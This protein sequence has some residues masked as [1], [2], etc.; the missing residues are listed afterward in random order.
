MTFRSDRRW[1]AIALV[2]VLVASA[3]SSGSATDESESPPTSEPTDGPVSVADIEDGELSVRLRTGQP[4]DAAAQDPTPI[5]NGEPLDPTEVD[6]ILDRLGPWDVPTDDRQDFSRPAETLL[7][8]RTG[9]TV[10][11]PFPAG[12]EDPPPEP[13]AGPLEI[14]R[15]QP[16]GDV[17]IAPSISLTFNQPMVA[18]GTVDQTDAA[19]VPITISPEVAG[20]WQWIGTKT[21]RF[22]HDSD[23][24]DRLPMAT[25]YTVEVPAGTTSTTGGELAETVGF[26]FATPTVQLVSFGPEN[27]SLPLEPVFVATFDQHI[28]TEAV[29]ATITV[30]A[31]GEPVDVR[32]ASANEIEDDDTAAR[33]VDQAIDGRFVAFRADDPLPADAELTIRFGPDLPS[34]EGPRTNDQPESR[35]AR[36][37]A[38][39]QVTDHNCTSSRKCQPWDQLRVEFNNPL[40]E[41]AFDNS[42]VEIEPTVGDAVVYAVGTTINI[43]GTFEGDTTY[44]VTLDK[45]ITD[46]HGQQLADTQDIEFHIGAA[47]PSLDQFQNPLLTLDPFAPEPAVSVTTVNHDALR[48]RLFAVDPSEWSTFIAYGRSWFDD[49]NFGVGTPPWT[50]VTDTTIDVD[51][52]SNVRA[53]TLIDLS[54]AIDGEHGHVVVLV[55]PVGALAELSQQDDD[56]WSNR[57]TMVWAQRTDLGVDAFADNRDLV[58]WTTDLGTGKIRS[59]VEVELTVDNQ[60]ATSDQQGLARL[61]LPG[62]PNNAPLIAR[63]GDDSMLLQGGWQSWSQQNDRLWHVFDDRAMYRPGETAH[64]KGWV[65]KLTLATDTQLAPVDAGATVSYTVTDP[66][67]NEIAEGTMDVNALGGFDF[68]VDIP[69]GANLGHAN[70]EFALDGTGARRHYHSFQV[71]EFRRPEF[72]VR[73]RPESPAPYFVDQPATVAVDAT[74]FSGGPLPDADVE[75]VVTTDTA[76]YAPP[77]WPDFTF[78]TW[79]PCWDYGFESVGR[80]FAEVS[81]AIDGDY[82][83]GPQG[84][85]VAVE[86]FTAVT[87][88]DGSHYLEMGFTGDGDD[89]PTTVR[90]QAT[91]FDINR[92]AWSSTANL[93]VH[94]ADVYVGLR[95]SR[96]FVRQGEPL[97]IEAIVT[98]LDGEPVNGRPVELEAS[99]LEWR[100]QDG[101]WT[102]VAVDPETCQITST[103][104]AGECSFATDHGGTY[105]ISAAV[106]DEQGRQNRSEL[107]R[108]VSGGDSRPDRRVRQERVTL[109][110]GQEEYQPGDTAEILVQSP[111]GPAEGLVTVVRNGLVSTDTFTAADGS[112]VV[113]VPITDDLI[114]G[115]RVQVDLVGETPR[116]NVDGAPQTDLPPRPAFAT[117]SLDLSVPPTL[118]ALTVTAAPAEAE[119]EP[120]A[121]TSV[122]VEVTDAAGEPVSGAEVAVVVVDEAVLALTGYQLADPNDSFYGR[123]WGDD[124]DTRYGR[125]GIEL[126]ANDRFREVSALI[127]GDAGDA[128]TGDGGEALELSGSPATTTAGFNQGAEEDYAGRDPGD[129]AAPDTPIDV[130]D[131]FDALALFTPDETTGTDGTLSVDVDL[132]DSLTRYRVMAVAVAD[133]DSFGSGEANLTARLPIMVRPSAPRFLN[134][135]DTFEL[136][137]LVQNQ[138]DQDLDVE[139]AIETA[140]LALT[141]AA[142]QRVSVPANNRVEVRFAAEADDAGTARFRVAGVSGDHADAASGEL[143]VYTPTTSEAFATYGVVDD[144]T[145]SQP[146]L[147]PTDVVPQFGGLE[148]GTSS[149]ALQALTD[150]VLYL[151]D[152]RYESSDALA[153]RIMAVAALRDVLDAFSAE[154]LPSAAELDAAVDRDIADL[155]ALQNGDGGF[156]YWRRGDRSI[157]YNSIQSVHALVAAEQ[158]GYSLPSGAKTQGLDYLRSIEN[159][160]PPEYSQAIRNTL[161]A[162]ALNVRSLADDRDP[163]KAV[164]LY[165]RAGDSLKLDALAWLWPVLDDTV[166][167]AEIARTFENRATETAG[168]ATFATDYGDD[169]YVILHSSRRTDGIILRSLVSESPESDLIPKVVAGLLGNQTKGR[170]NNVQEN[171]FILLALNDYFDTF[172]S[173]TPDFV[174]RVWLGDLYA[175]EHTYQGRSTDRGETLVP[176]AELIESGDADI[177]VAKDGAGRLYYRLGLRYAPADLDL[178]PRDRGFVVQRSYEAVDDPDDVRRDDDGTWQVRAGAEVRV[179]LTMVA[180]SR[181]THVALTDPLPA[182]LEPLNPA[183]AVTP[184]V[185]APPDGDDDGFAPADIGFG[186]FP[187]YPWW[188]WYE[189]QNLRDDR[190]EAFTSLLSGGTYEYS[191]VARATTPG[192]FVVPPTKA[193]EIYAPE[194]FGRTAT[195]RLVVS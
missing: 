192:T 58:V 60:S 22:E 153:S 142:G 110:P 116:I 182:G 104:E 54:D 147:A 15:Y 26:Q 158:A 5:V 10:E 99:R 44:R 7:P 187:I 193:E 76:T 90:A 78:C 96:P 97:L 123:F 178:D 37:F 65:R 102:E 183:L 45:T 100:Y 55:E 18:L 143:P 8:P 126:T 169:A 195:D 134:F 23:L 31:N 138:T 135:G 79:V 94:P 2:F 52:E 92:Q 93:L 131:N 38:S 47:R 108:W 67:G 152:Y 49:E 145:I 157:P 63:S 171:V 34:A 81:V 154:G 75:W 59:G 113:E 136:P 144:G 35:T 98:D 86:T 114:P 33:L 82:Y 84:E 115:A 46:I 189:H 125:D 42:H 190:A 179:N 121:Q 41:A 106:T 180:D 61:A 3:C 87:G 57:P 32:L 122:A 73:A 185:P 163:A 83:P 95:S 71:Q 30:E 137:V 150:A 160:F 14:L 124:L 188:Q 19:D 159:H 20:R 64:F 119:V 117:G 155:V 175:G 161:S 69:E 40:D 141:E 80:G 16:E 53:E 167:R 140:N 168:A 48:V 72:E 89:Q 162:Y 36:T 13:P 166:A 101:E 27:D 156:P 107:T 28:D 111:F 120:G 118:R 164:S 128:A 149:T 174:A 50:A 139:V 148:V 91:V 1:F 186:F 105:E 11:Q 112:A 177:V 6:T 165:N 39:L 9:E 194:V 132:P 24:I 77:N 29:L 172:E 173:V 56:F 127:D 66:Q 170:W 130:R 181:R 4:V 17:D 151:H 70:V 12:G 184:D 129:D 25:A 85:P 103:G 176:M 133:T 43:D 51:A 62:S 109:V 191:Y 68:E 146:L 88:P 21:V 74:Y